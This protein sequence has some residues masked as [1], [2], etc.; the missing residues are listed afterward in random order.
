MY[1]KILTAVAVGIIVGLFA[2]LVYQARPITNNFALDR[3]ALTERVVSANDLYVN[4]A[5]RITSGGDTAPVEGLLELLPRFDLVASRLANDVSPDASSSDDQ[6]LLVERLSEM[7]ALLRDARTATSDLIEHRTA[8]QAILETVRFEGPEVVKGL[9][10]A[11]TTLTAQRTFLVLAEILDYAQTG[12]DDARG[13]ISEEMAL[14]RRFQETAA[15]PR[16]GLL[17]TSIA[18]LMQEK[19][20]AIDATRRFASADTQ[21][22]SDR[23]LSGLGRIPIDH[24]KRADRAW[25]MLSVYSGLL[26]LALFYLTRRF[27]ENFDDLIDNNFA[28]N[29]LNA[30]VD[31]IVEERTRGLNEAYQ[32]LRATEEE[33]NESEKI[34]S[35]GRIVAGI[36]QEMNTPLWYLHNNATLISERLAKLEDFVSK[37]E[38]TLNLIAGQNTDKQRFLAGLAQLRQMMGGTTLR[39]DTQ[40]AHELIRDSVAGLEEIIGFVRGLDT[41]VKVEAGTASQTNINQLLDHEL[42]ACPDLQDGDRQIAVHKDYGKLP[43]VFCVDTQIAT[44][45]RHLINNA[46]QAI[47]GDGEIHIISREDDERVSVTIVDTGCGIPTELLTKVCEPFFTTRKLG[48]GAGLGLAVSKQI[49]EAHG[50]ELV[51]ESASGQGSLVTIEL[52]VDGGMPAVI[53]GASAESASETPPAHE[54]LTLEGGTPSAAPA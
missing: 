20:S 33:L 23:L 50:G 21:Q 39:D 52:P 38:E 49:V 14:L 54:E 1:R 45:F 13:A 3:T 19:E 11:G 35:V 10:E 18:E 24:S 31:N 40:E 8:L 48:H 12:S 37:S 26:A 32:N 30:R 47:D 4:T 9:R 2:L 16:L 15:E 27:R 46:V 7:S 29:R 25:L 28:L 41:H 6:R 42:Q 34:A 43:S 17:L 36:T 44:V 53:E 51:I 22:A 5:N